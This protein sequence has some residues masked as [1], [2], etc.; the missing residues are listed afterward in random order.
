M[1]DQ[2]R[3]MFAIPMTP[4]DEHDRVDE[5]VLRA[6][7][8]FCV[9]SG[10]GGL[11]VPVMV[12]EFRLLSEAE[13]RTLIRI[14][15]EV[16]DGR[17]PIMANC[18]A[19]NTP[20]AVEY[21]VYAEQVGA[22]AVIAMP[23]Y[24]LGTDYDSIFAYYKAIAEAVSIPVWVQNANVAPLSAEQIVRLC[25]EIDNVDYVKQEVTPSTHT[26][27]AVINQQSPAVKG[28]MG[29]AG[30]RFLMTERARG[31]VGCI[32]ACEFCDV[33]QRVWDLMDEGKE[34][35]AQDLFDIVLPGVVLEGLM[36]MGFAKEIMVR[37]GVLQNNKIRNRTQTLDKHDLIEIDRVYER[38]EPHFVWNKN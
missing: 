1:T 21:A 19:V 2:W 23:P 36:G 3:G 5:D 14:P 24:I 32:I 8:E 31:A 10:V 37:R 38:L 33:L 17:V 22:D 27:S 25:E 11:C 12:S 16:S 15:V 28:V 9:Q 34:A 20:L 18:A 35:E 6:E 30:G 4:F 26:I 13:R 29:G 7:V